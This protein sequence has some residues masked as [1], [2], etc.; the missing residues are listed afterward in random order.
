MKLPN[1]FGSVYKMQGNR[2]CPF[3]AIITERWILDSITGKSKQ[4]RITIGYYASRK[5]AL[6]ALAEYN[7]SPYNLE[8]SKITFQEVYERWSDA[9]FPTVS[10]S[11][12]KG[13]KASYSL[14]KSIENKRM[15]D[16]K[17]DDLQYIADTSGKNTPTLR[18]YK[19]LM[20]LVFKYAVVHDII[21][22]DMNKTQY[23]DIK[24][25]GNP[26]ARN[27]EPFSNKEIEKLWKWVN[28]NV[29]F[30]V[31]LI[32]IYSGVRISELLDLKKENVNIKERW[33]DVVAS[34][35]DAGVRK[36]PIANKILPFFE[37]WYNL[38]DCE[39][40][41]S[42]PESNHFEYRNYYDSYWK[43]LIEQLSLKHTP[44]DTRHTCISLL[45]TVG[46]DERIIK[47]IV[48]HKGLGVTQQVYTHLE[49]Q[50]LL[51]A[52]DKI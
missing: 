23:I 11:N 20:G 24:K 52:I 50:T 27:R 42:T 9:H 2:R 51:E 43:P 30:N 28:T 39:Y 33:F 37:Y 16:I 19:S 1:G 48:G 32:L 4:K 36:V 38:N 45:T 35:T 12:I 5:Q 40:L 46:V 10:E 6:E 18:K 3:R 13:Y 41:I 26:N 47:K 8:A 7:K 21:S 31:I 17:L 14:C 29:Y 15:V 44:H 22:P 49:I 34:K 25:A